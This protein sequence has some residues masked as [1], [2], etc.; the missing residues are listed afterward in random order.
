MPVCRSPSLALLIC[1]FLVTAGSGE[2]ISF[3]GQIR[4]ILKA[5]CFHCHGEADEL[6]GKL[7]VRLARLILKGGETGPAVAPG[8]PTESL[9][10]AKVKS[11][12]MPEGER[13]LSGEQVALIEKWIAGG[14][15]TLRPEPE[16]P[17]QL[18][19]TEEERSFW[20]FQ[21]VVRPAVPEG[22]SAESRT[23]IDLFLLQKL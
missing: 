20:S 1:S 2:E 11:G 21:P 18:V 14:A 3:E 6:Q 19:F 5:N 9:L 12:E 13:K 4:P 15:K 7:D 22:H 16:D 17:A 10:L 8:K 23:S